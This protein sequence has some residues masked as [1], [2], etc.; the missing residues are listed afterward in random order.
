MAV[1]LACSEN[2]EGWLELMAERIVDRG[3]GEFDNYSGIGVFA[4]P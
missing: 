1:D 2:P 4:D 3:S